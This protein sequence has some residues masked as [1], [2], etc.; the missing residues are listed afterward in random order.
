MPHNGCGPKW[1]PKR[2]K[3]LLFNWFFEASCNK[4]DEGYFAGGNERRRY[5]C[6]WKF[7]QAMK[8]D[9]LRFKG[10]KRLAMWMQALL[11]FGLVR[12]FGWSSFNYK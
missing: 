2:I 4:H 7:W 6:D 11:F 5:V 3:E 12:A 8:R 9:A 1:V 10:I